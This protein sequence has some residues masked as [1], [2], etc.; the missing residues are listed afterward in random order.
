[1][2]WLYNQYS[3]CSPGISAIGSQEL[4][5]S[6]AILG[7]KLTGL[8]ENVQFISLLQTQKSGNIF[9]SRNT[10][11]AWGYELPWRCCTQHWAR[12]WNR[13]KNI[14]RK[15][16]L[17]MGSWLPYSRGAWA[18]AAAFIIYFAG[19]KIYGSFPSPGRVQSEAHTCSSCLVFSSAPSGVYFHVQGGKLCEGG[20]KLHLYHKRSLDSH[21]PA[22][23]QTQSTDFSH[24]AGAF[25]HPRVKQLNP[26]G[27]KGVR[28]NLW[29]WRW[30]L[31]KWLHGPQPLTFQTSRNRRG[32]EQCLCIFPSSNS[33]S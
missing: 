30:S 15:K 23:S 1:M 13:N 8:V 25:Q 6:A 19:T 24:S 18:Q 9:P 7:V 29:I 3:L 32:M 21:S 22:H 27:W 12:K 5:D 11:V 20:E 28:H 31:W 4:L 14:Y 33:V 2:P 16:S 26:G 17:H 10:L